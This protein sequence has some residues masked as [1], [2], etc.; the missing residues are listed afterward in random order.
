MRLKH[1]SIRNFIAQTEFDHEFVEPITIFAGP[2]AAGKSSIRDAISVAWSGT[3]RGIPKNARS[4]MS[5]SPEGFGIAASTLVDDRYMEFSS[6]MTGDNPA[7]GD[8]AKWLGGKDIVYHLTD[9]RAW[10]LVGK[11]K[12]HKLLNSIVPQEDWRGTALPSDLEQVR[13]DRGI[14]ACMTAATQQ[15]RGMAK[16]MADY[17]QPEAPNPIATI[18]GQEK[19]VD[20]RVLKLDPI[21][22]ELGKIDPAIRR[23]TGQL[24]KAVILTETG[25]EKEKELSELAAKIP[26]LE[27][28]K[29]HCVKRRVPLNRAATTAGSARGIATNAYNESHVKLEIAGQACLLSGVCGTCHQDISPEYADKIKEDHAVCENNH[30]EA[31]VELEKVRA[32][33]NEANACAERA[34]Q[35]ELEIGVMLKEA[36]RA[37]KELET[38]RERIQEAKAEGLDYSKLEL[39]L[40]ALQSRREFL[41]RASNAIENYSWQTEQHEKSKVSYKRMLSNMKTME[42]ICASIEENVKYGSRD[43]MAVCEKH[44]KTLGDYYGTEIKLGADY[45]PGMDGIPFQLLCESDQYLGLVAIQ[46][47]LALVSGIKFVFIDSLDRLTA[48][49]IKLLRR[50]MQ[51]EV[52]GSGVQVVAAVARDEAKPV[53]QSPFQ[54]VPLTH[55]SGATSSKLD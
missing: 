18:E 55:G 42:E 36:K 11:D 19:P 1:L 12:R 40:T 47:A 46:Y 20:L 24:T 22:D 15:R 37:N 39:D 13:T 3:T 35:D 31:W 48:E 23:I 9:H 4:S 51:I 27:E 25:A 45:M 34:K 16:Q 2:N 10:E 14:H 8:R 54:V 21:L 52:V 26:N 17:G 44:I 38:Y 50:W 49:R 29:E 32:E 43:V 33:W 41:H 30:K 7:P 5:R 53:H 28:A 6:T